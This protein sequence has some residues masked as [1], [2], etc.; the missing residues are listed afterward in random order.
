MSRVLVQPSVRKM[1][2]DHQLAPGDPALERLS[3]TRGADEVARSEGDQGRS[4]DLAQYRARVVGHSRLG[5][6]QERVHGL[7]GPATYEVHQRV[8]ELGPFDVHL[9]REAPREDGLTTTSATVGSDDA[10]VR[11]CST[12]IFR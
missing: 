10:S 6:G 12:T 2:E 3:E 9:R 7:G 8:D 1:L 4:V 5:L 11:H